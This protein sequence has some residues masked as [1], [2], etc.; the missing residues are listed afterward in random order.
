MKWGLAVTWLGAIA[1]VTTACG[2]SPTEIGLNRSFH[3]E[4][5]TDTA[6]RIALN[7]E[8]TI[9]AVGGSYTSSPCSPS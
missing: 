2:D 3:H 4:A 9:R 6:M 5:G 1:F 7:S 8:Q